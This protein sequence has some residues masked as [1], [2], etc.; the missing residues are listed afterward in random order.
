[1]INKLIYGILIITISSRLVAFS[2]E[3]I[4]T[5]LVQK[6]DLPEGH[7]TLAPAH[8]KV[9]EAA[10]EDPNSVT[11]GDAEGYIYCT[12]QLWL[13]A[14][15]EMDAA[16]QSLQASISEIMADAE[17]G[18]RTLD[19][20][21]IGPTK[22]AL[23]LHLPITAPIEMSFSHLLVPTDEHILHIAISIPAEYEGEHAGRG[24]RFTRAILLSLQDSAGRQLKPAKQPDVDSSISRQTLL[25]KTKELCGSPMDRTSDMLTTQKHYVFPNS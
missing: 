17:I 6:I 14:P 1:M 8:L 22:K 18:E 24:T 16:L 20:F 13:L 5:G 21:T 19:Y 11:F 4:A 12:V 3:D 10:K 15:Q 9:I 25:Q 2:S 23:L 7:S